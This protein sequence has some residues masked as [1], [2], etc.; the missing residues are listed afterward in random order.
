[1][2]VADIEVVVEADPWIIVACVKDE[3]LGSEKVAIAVN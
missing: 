2:L 3:R 1:V